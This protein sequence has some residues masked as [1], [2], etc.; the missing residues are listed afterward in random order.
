MPRRDFETPIP[1]GGSNSSFLLKGSISETELD[2]ELLADLPLLGK[3]TLT[4]IRGD[5][6]D[7][8]ATH[9]SFNVGLWSGTVECTIHDDW[10]FVALTA[11]MFGQSIG[12]VKVRLFYIPQQLLAKL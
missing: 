2:A 11:G 3:V 7:G 12:P 1:I 8:L 5:V 9:N 4:H 6:R 10:L